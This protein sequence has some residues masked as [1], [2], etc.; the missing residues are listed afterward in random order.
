MECLVKIADAFQ[1]WTIFAKRSNLDVKQCSEY[2]FDIRTIQ[3]SCANMLRKCMWWMPWHFKSHRSKEDIILNYNLPL[4]RKHF[5]RSSFT[6]TNIRLKLF[7][8]AIPKL[9]QFCYTEVASLRPCS[10]F[11]DLRFWSQNKLFKR[12]PFYSTCS[13]CLREL[14]DLITERNVTYKVWG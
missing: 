7:F 13:S 8:I 4:F 6:E 9:L 1:P 14:M 10:W 11:F 5:K 3:A 12:N 2:A